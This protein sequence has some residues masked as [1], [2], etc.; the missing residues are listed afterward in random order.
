MYLHFHV[1]PNFATKIMLYFHFGKVSDVFQQF[2]NSF[3]SNLR[4]C[5]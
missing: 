4:N 3:T 1:D 2:Y 5:L